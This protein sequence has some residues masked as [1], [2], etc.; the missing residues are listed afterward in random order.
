M[1]EYGKGQTDNLKAVGKML[2]YVEEEYAVNSGDDDYFIPKSLDKC[3]DFL[4]NNPDYSS[5]HGNGTF[6][7]HNKDKDK[8]KN[9]IR[10]NY[11]INSYNADSASERLKMV[12]N[13]YSVSLFSVHRTKVFKSA[14]RNCNLLENVSFTEYLPV[15][16]SAV[17]GKSYKLKE[18]YLIRGIH[19]NRDVQKSLTEEILD[20]QWH[21]SL[22]IHLNT[23]S[24]EIGKIDEIDEIESIEIVKQGFSDLLKE[25]IKAKYSR[26][27]T[28]S[29]KFRQSIPVSIKRFIRKYILPHEYYDRTGKL[30]KASPY[31][32][33]FK[34][35][36][37]IDK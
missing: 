23:L 9:I 18:L 28:F 15:C 35:L 33:E 5:A 17:L 16:M 1:P 21:K 34:S 20:P 4:E 37:N 31:Y 24:E 25:G 22:Q 36:L 7:I 2:E 3:V 32:Y 29:D 14:F 19:E 27:D 12:S 26:K 10:G 6:L 8:D 30:S 11:N 13:K